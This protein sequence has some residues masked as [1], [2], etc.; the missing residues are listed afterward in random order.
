MNSVKLTRLLVACGLSISFFVPGALAQPAFESALK[1]LKFRSI[2]PA[3]MGGRVDDIA[4]VESDP[5]IIYVGA[6]G[7]GLFKTVNGGITWQALFED[8]PNPSIGDIAHCAVESVDPLRRHGRGEQP[9]EFVVGQ[10]R[11]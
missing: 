6:A 2:G 8:Q 10:R 7:G 11:L 5:R 3:T 4:V 9:P 1:N